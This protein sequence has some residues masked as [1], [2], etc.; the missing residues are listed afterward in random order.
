V[1]RR[2]KLNIDSG[3]VVSD[4]VEVEL[5]DPIVTVDT[6]LQERIEKL[7]NTPQ[8]ANYTEEQLTEKAQQLIDRQEAKTTVV[9][10]G[11]VEM[12]F[13]GLFQDLTEKRQAK[14]LLEKY[15]K[16]F[17]PRTISEKND[18]RALLYL[19]IIQVRLQNVMNKMQQETDGA[20][21]LKTMKAIHENLNE[22]STIKEKIGLQGKT[23]GQT[24]DAYKNWELLKEKAKIWRENNST[25]R[26][27]NC[28]HCGEMTLLKI[29]MDN[30]DAT[31]HNFFKG[32]FLCNHHLMKMYIKGKLTKKDLALVYETSED[33]IDWLVDKWYT[34]NT[35]FIEMKNKQD[36][37]K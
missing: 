19:E 8:Y 25:E 12:N 23:K 16:D 10:V 7:R 36:E 24:S 3:S 20:V 27:L 37:N 29:S 11:N 22:I 18:I 15:L 2:R 13:T 9:K 35:E 33:Y 28:P 6:V 26:T 31:K 5:P 17:T 4:S 21:H 30:F 32:R 34:N 14:K 1:G